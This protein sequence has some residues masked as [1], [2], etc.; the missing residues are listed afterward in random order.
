VAIEVLIPTLAGGERLAAALDSLRRQTR[1]PRVCVIDNGVGKG[2]SELAERFDEVRWVRPGRNL[3]F[4]AA[5]NRG[6]EG[7]TAELLIFLN[8]DAVADEQM[9]ERIAAVREESGAEMVAACLVAPD[10]RVDSAGVDVDRSLIAYD[11]FHGRPYDEIAASPAAPM[12]PSAGAGGYDRAAFTAVGGFDER[13][14]AYLEDVELGL[15]MRAAGMRCVAALD[16]IAWHHH[17]A[18]LGSGSARKNRLMGTSR[19]YLLRKYRDQ[20]GLVDRARG[21][22]IDGVTYAGQVAID[23]NAGAARG[24]LAARSV[25]VNGARWPAAELARVPSVNVSG[26]RAL[27]IRLSRRRPG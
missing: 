2:T 20:L 3:G 14:F 22:V 21:A 15:R 18:T 6:A 24:R 19:G 23:R 17:S 5:L 25:S 7:S 16:A 27:A 13:F 26:P 1:R 10:G 8:D 11:L 4:G 12:A 9:V